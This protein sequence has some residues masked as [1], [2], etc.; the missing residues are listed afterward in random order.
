MSRKDVTMNKFKKIIALLLALALSLSLCLAF[1][2]CGDGDGDSADG[3]ADNGTNNGGANNGG[4]NNGGNNDGGSGNG[5]TGGVMG[6][7]TYT[8]NL[9]DPN[10]N[11]IS[12]SF[13]IEIPALDR[14]LRGRNGTVSFTDAAGE[15]AFTLD[16]DGKYEYDESK[17]VVTP[18]NNVVDIYLYSVVGR[19]Q[20]IQ[21][22][23]DGHVDRDLNCYCDKCWGELNTN[24]KN[25][26]GDCLCDSCERPCHT[27]STDDAS[28]CSVCGETF[29]VYPPLEGR[30]SAEAVGVFAGTSLLKFTEEGIHYIIFT[31]TEGGIYKF[32]TS[33][34]GVSAIGYYGAPHF[35]QAVSS[36][37]VVDG[38]FYITI[39][40]SAIG[41]DEG[42]TSQF[43][44]GIT[45]TAAADVAF[46]IER[47]AAAPVQLPYLDIPASSIAK[48]YTDILNDA[49]VDIDIRESGTLVVLGADGYYHY[50]TA[51]GPL[52]LVK[53]NT[54]GNSNLNEFELAPFITMTETDRLCCYFYDGNGN[55]TRKESYNVMIETYSGYAG[56]AGLVPLDET[57]ATAIKNMGNHM[58][59]WTK[60]G[61][62]ANYIFGMNNVDVDNAWLFACAYVDADA[63]GSSSSPILAPVSDDAV[64]AIRLEA[65]EVIY[66]RPT[67]SVAGQLTLVFKGAAGV[68][69]TVGTTEYTADDNGKITVTTNPGTTMTVTSTEDVTVTLTC[70]PAE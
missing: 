26:D 6:D 43:V 40:N 14:R 62:N 31:P 46:T 49:L 25:T 47:T 16:L 42:G 56:T 48:P 34:A 64:N 60:T 59:W 8:V 63:Y 12:E 5:G 38:A 35:V 17:A 30:R 45:T 51:D 32:S 13:V 36:V 18:T 2:S 54:S 7:I 61:T 19:T 58:G 22:P 29:Y 44:L 37:E 1:V 9:K 27:P 65:G 69:V 52:V 24:H 53:I 21:V 70:R 11:P 15:Y 55:V 50:G 10:G 57:L 4:A 20:T 28:V 33:S 68:S 41:T 23:C 66:V 67:S 39:P 3:G